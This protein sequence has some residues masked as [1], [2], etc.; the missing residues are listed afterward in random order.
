MIIVVTSLLF[1]EMM[2]FLKFS[3]SKNLIQRFAERARAFGE[4]GACFWAK[5]FSSEP[6][7]TPIRIAAWCFFADLMISRKAFLFAMFPGLMRILSAP[8]SRARIASRGLKWISAISGI[9][10]F[11]LMLERAFAAFSVGTATRI[12]SHPAFS[13]FLIWEIVARM[14]SVFV[15][16][17]DW[18][19]MWSFPILTLP[20]F[21]LF[22]C[23]FL[24][25]MLFFMLSQYCLLVF[26]PWL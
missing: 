6:S 2:R 16:H 4:W 21:T 13:S 3:F 11:F 7:F 19:E 15:L 18:I 25:S 17:I 5:S 8:F 23:I 24:F 20:T 1:A 14:S 22:I 10:I 9:E 26:H 12:S